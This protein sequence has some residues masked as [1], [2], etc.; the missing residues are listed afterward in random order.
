MYFD[1]FFYSTLLSRKVSLT[2]GTLQG[3]RAVCQGRRK[4][5]WSWLVASFAG[6]ERFASLY[7][8]PPPEATVFRKFLRRMAGV[9]QHGAATLAQGA[10]VAAAKAVG[11]RSYF[12]SALLS[13]GNFV[14]FGSFL[15]RFHIASARA[16]RYCI[17]N[18]A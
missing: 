5:C 7:H 14:R 15:T 8:R 16:V 1:P 18:S 17:A 2:L 10:A 12:A 3:E 9:R 4:K 6:S 11:E 13:P